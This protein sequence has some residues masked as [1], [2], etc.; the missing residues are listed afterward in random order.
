MKKVLITGGAGG[1]GFE[2]TKKFIEN[3]YFAYV[4]DTDAEN[5]E[6]LTKCFGGDRCEIVSL[7]VTDVSAIRKYVASLDKDFSLDHIITLAGRALDGEWKPFEN[8]DLEMIQSSVNLNLLGHINII[9]SFLPVLKSGEGDKSIVMISSINAITNFNLPAYSA[10]KA[11]LVGFMNGI[12]RELGKEGVRI[13]TVSPGT[14]KTPATLQEPKD[15]EQLLK[16]T[17]INRFATANEVAKMIYAICNDFVSVT[18]QNYIIDA[19]QS[20]SH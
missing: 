19:G 8:Q 14:V 15:Y 17:A 9:H 5:C 12:V 4:F 13:N 6:K 16:T 1:I 7:D 3:G 18:G 11:G 2:I 20:Q 10:A